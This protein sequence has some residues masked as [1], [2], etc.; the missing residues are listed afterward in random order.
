MHFMR[1]KVL[2]VGGRLKRVFAK[3][4]L[5]LVKDERLQSKSIY[6][7]RNVAFVCLPAVV[8]AGDEH[9]EQE[10]LVNH[11]AKLFFT[12]LFIA[13]F[14]HGRT[15]ALVEHLDN[16]GARHMS[17]EHLLQRVIVEAGDKFT[18]FVKVVAHALNMIP[19]AHKHRCL[20]GQNDLGD[21]IHKKLY[22]RFYRS[23]MDAGE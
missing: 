6:F 13:E 12:R 1:D 2:E 7:Q 20:V 19:C 14:E 17:G 8:I 4:A 18:F 23:A 15:E 10:E 16:N 22:I 3:Y 5:Y 11:A 21:L 9:V